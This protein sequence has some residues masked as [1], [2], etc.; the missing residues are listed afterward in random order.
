VMSIEYMLMANGLHT[1]VWIKIQVMQVGEITQLWRYPS[2]KVGM[3]EVKI[4]Q[5][6]QGAQEPWY[7][8]HIEDVA[9]EVQKL[10]VP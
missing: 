3:W 1:R 9:A 6:M 4:S 8:R 7:W 2:N 5:A 10:E